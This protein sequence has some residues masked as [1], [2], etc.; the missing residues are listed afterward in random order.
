MA[1]SPR[2]MALLVDCLSAGRAAASSP[3]IQFTDARKSIKQDY[4]SDGGQAKF[5]ARTFADTVQLK[6]GDPDEVA[7]T[8]AEA[9]NVVIPLKTGQPDLPSP[10]SKD[11]VRGLATHQDLM[12]WITNNAL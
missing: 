6:D 7:Y 5:L 4:A 9:I 11:T 10:L 2:S 12:D 1:Y 8:K 3:P